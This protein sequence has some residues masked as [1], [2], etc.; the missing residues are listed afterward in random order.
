MG[1][2]EKISYKREFSRS[3]LTNRSNTQYMYKDYEPNKNYKM[4]RTVKT[5]SVFA[6]VCFVERTPRY[7]SFK[8]HIFIGS[9]DISL[10]F[11]R[12]QRPCSCR[13]RTSGVEKLTINRGIEAK[14][15][16]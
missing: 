8:K 1:E 7:R 6:F 12:I 2:V 5:K 4:T 14:R 3:V 10:G 15:V 13:C 16:A 9:S 11:V